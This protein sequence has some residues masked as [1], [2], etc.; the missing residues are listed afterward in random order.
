MRHD[1][2]QRGGDLVWLDADV[3]ETR[4]RIGGVV[5]MERRQHEVSGERRLHRD[6]RRLLVADFADEDDVRVLA[7]NRA[8]R[9]RERQS[10]LLLYLHLHDALHPV[11]D[12]V[13]D[14][15]DVHALTLDLIDRRVERRGFAGPGWAGNEKDAFV[16]L[17][18]PLDRV[19]FSRVQAQ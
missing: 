9:R 15:H 12:R 17:E 11:F 10:G 2:A 5:G 16:I 7:Q 18:Q 3:D 8:Q 4:D 1:A 14:R 6:L 19:R 13:F